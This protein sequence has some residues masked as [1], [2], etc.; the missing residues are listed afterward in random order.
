MLK[1]FDI[2]DDDQEAGVTPA[3]GNACCC[4]CVL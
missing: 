3:Y 4:C 1:H 2:Y